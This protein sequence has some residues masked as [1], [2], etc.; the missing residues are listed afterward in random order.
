MGRHHP[1]ISGHVEH[2]DVVPTLRRR[3]KR[4]KNGA[5][6]ATEGKTRTREVTRLRQVHDEAAGREVRETRTWCD[7]KWSETRL[8]FSPGRAVSWTDGRGEERVLDT[9]KVDGKNV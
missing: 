1:P 5:P 7:A 9:A 3:R 4:S 8:S 2:F 6:T